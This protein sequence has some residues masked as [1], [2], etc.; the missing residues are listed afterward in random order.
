MY[1]RVRVSA[2]MC[3]CVYV[4]CVSVCVCV[5][6]VYTFMMVLVWYSMIALLSKMT[7]TNWFRSPKECIECLVL[8]MSW[9]WNVAFNQL[10]NRA[11]LVL[12][13]I[14]WD[15]AGLKLLPCKSKL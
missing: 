14:I 15:G 2:F 10:S 7:Q 12:F 3:T 9:I 4:R 13:E 1:M 6:C 8:C 5:F 11:T